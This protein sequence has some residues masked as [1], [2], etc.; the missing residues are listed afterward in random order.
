MTIKEKIVNLATDL[1]QQERVKFVMWVSSEEGIEF[2]DAWMICTGEDPT[3]IMPE[4]SLG[5]KLASP[6]VQT[7][8]YL[9]PGKK[10]REKYRQKFRE[11]LTPAE[12]QLFD[13]EVNGRAVRSELKKKLK[14]AK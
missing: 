2:D 4:Y 11:S 14:H 5:F 9:Q 7:S 8:L 6:V 13:E 12:L 10:N 3:R 1:E